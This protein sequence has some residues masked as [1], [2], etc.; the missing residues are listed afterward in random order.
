M[1]STA[2][3]LLSSGLTCLAVGFLTQATQAECPCEIGARPMAPAYPNVGRIPRRPTQ[4]LTATAPPGTL[5]RTYDLPSRE[6]PA[7]KHPRIAMIDVLVRDAEVVGVYNIN[8]HREEDEIEGFQAAGNDAL[9]QF[10]TKPLMPGV[11]HIY[12]V[13]FTFDDDA[14]ARETVRYVRLIPGRIVTLVY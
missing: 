14:N 10:E 7:E 3:K 5:G 12:K 2:T 11:P 1:L 4:P 13:V 9:W 8:P 6:I